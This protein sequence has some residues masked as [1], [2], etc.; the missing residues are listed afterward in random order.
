M[1]MENI[2]IKNLTFQ[3][4]MYIMELRVGNLESILWFL[5]D[6]FRGEFGL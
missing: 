2:V 1:E 6:A 5:E 3:N 4:R